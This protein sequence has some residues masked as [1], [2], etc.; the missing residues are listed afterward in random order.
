[1]AGEGALM[2]KGGGV[3]LDD[4]HQANALGESMAG[5]YGGGTNAVIVREEGLFL[6]YGHQGQPAGRCMAGKE[7]QGL[8]VVP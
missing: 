8:D 3:F 4:G 7:K 1:M 2:F 6:V 5:G